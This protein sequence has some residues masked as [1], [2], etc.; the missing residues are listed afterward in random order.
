MKSNIIKTMCEQGFSYSLLSV[1][2]LLVVTESKA[3]KAKHEF[4]REALV[5]RFTSEDPTIGQPLRK[6]CT[7]LTGT[8]MKHI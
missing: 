5:L 7:S 3:K 6:I 1:F 8:Y 2:G 4:K